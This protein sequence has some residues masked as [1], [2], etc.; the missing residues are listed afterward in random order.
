MLSHPLGGSTIPERVAAVAATVVVEVVAVS[1][2]LLDAE[3]LGG[4]ESGIFES[5]YSRVE[6]R[7]SRMY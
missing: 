4:G 5:Q 2:V 1:V 6:V 3:E 7:L